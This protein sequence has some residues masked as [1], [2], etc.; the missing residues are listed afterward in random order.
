VA[1]R[2]SL[3]RH[4]GAWLVLR[5]APSLE[6]LAPP[7]LPFSR[8]PSL[9]LLDALATLEAAAEDPRIV[10]VLLRFAGPL[11]GWSRALSLRRA[12]EAVRQRG[13]PVVAYGELFGAESLVVASGATRLWLPESGT[14]LLVGLRIDGLYLRPLLERLEIRPEVVRIGTHKTAGDRFTRERMS[15][16]ER[17][18]LEALADDLF[19]ALVEAIASGRG[20][21]AATVR[22]RIDAG[23]YAAPAAVEAG[24]ADGCLYPDEVERELLSLAPDTATEGPEGRPR[25]LDAAGYHSLHVNDPGWRPLLRDLP[26]IAYVVGRG[27]VHRGGGPRGIAS[28]TVRELLEGIRR[29]EGIRG[30]VLRLDSPG[31]DGVASD[32]VWRAVSLVAREKPVVVSIGDVAA[33]GGYY[34]AAA[35]DMLFAEAG[36]VTGSIGVVGGKLDLGGLYRRLGVTREGVERGARAGLLSETRGFTGEERAAMRELLASVH[37]TFVDRVARGRGLSSDSLARVTQGRVWSGRRARSLGLVDGIGGPLEAL[38]E[39]RKRAGLRDDDRYLLELHP[40]LPQLPGLVSLL[41]W[42]PGRMGSW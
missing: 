41:R 25:L 35:G 1:D 36:S 9:G 34:L 16:E 33:S 8:H 29:E 26:R 31:G 42:R 21:D 15:P 20:L 22:E 32:L 24:L 5:L 12:V 3:P 13:K 38:R 17:E 10:G 37:G 18:Q 7:H 23:P 19:E 40:R 30:V 11:E 28:D 27:V 2:A 6:E 4:G 14:L 39:V